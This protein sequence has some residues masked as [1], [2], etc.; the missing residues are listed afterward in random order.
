MKNLDSIPKR[1]REVIKY[2]TDH[3]D[4][5]AILTIRELA[6]KL[7][8]NHTTII[9]AC[10][11][12]GYKGFNDIKK[13]HKEAYK[14]NMTGYGIMLE[15]LQSESIPK[16]KSPLEEVIR[17][18][19]LTDLEVLNRTIAST[20]WETIVK[21]VTQIIN[22]KR[23]YIIGLEA[24]RSIAMFLSAELRTY[25]P[26]VE[27]IVY[28]NGYLFDYIRHFDKD[29]V[30]VGISFGKCIRQTVNAVKAA[31]SQ[32]IKT[33]S[34]TDSKLSPLYKYSDISL[35]TAS[36]SDSYFSTFIGA[37][38]ISKAMLVCCAELKGE[39][40]IEQ[41]QIIKQQWEEAKIYYEE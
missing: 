33:I 8:I 22:S 6:K 40:A 14:R 27:E 15:K 39:E 3:P 1:Q 36:A 4:D 20:S 26:N 18:S 5:I 10:K 9:R 25:L 7:N 31:N 19:L 11:E 38:S 35:L 41:L 37:M 16:K 13:H 17:G 24:A 21:A 23:T 2:L 29:D 12:L 30:V 28:T 32:G 34:I